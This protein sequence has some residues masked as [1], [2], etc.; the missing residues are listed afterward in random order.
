MIFL[1]VL[2][3]V[4]CCGIVVLWHNLT[5]LK[6]KAE[7]PQQ[8]PAEEN[9]LFESEGEVVENQDC[10]LRSGL[11]LGD[12]IC[13]LMSINKKEKIISMIEETIEQHRNK[14]IAF[15]KFEHH[16]SV[17]TNGLPE[18]LTRE[19]QLLK[20]DI[21][22]STLIYTLAGLKPTTI[23]Y[24]TNAPSVHSVHTRQSRIR[25][26]IKSLNNKQVRV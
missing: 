7:I 20:S 1:L 22:Y 2:V 3:A 18:L 9:I 4:L 17:A 24:L 14:G 6:R 8:L 13:Y 12:E 23:A 26:V 21:H 11:L 16:I 5:I 25:S 15:K 19:S 10:G